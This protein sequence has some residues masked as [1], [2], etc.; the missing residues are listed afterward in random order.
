[1]T[2]W[3][4]V[5][6]ELKAIAS[7]KAIAITLFGGVLFYSVLYPLPYLHEVPT[8]QPIVVVDLDHSP[9]SRELI[10]HAQAS[11][12]LQVAGAVNA[13][14]E[15]KDWITHGRAHGLLVIPAHFS[16]D[17][18]LGKGATLAIGGDAS[19]F[20]VYSAIAEGL[21]SVGMDFSSQL[22]WRALTARGTNP[23]AADMQ[24]H[25]LDIN[26]VP[27]FNLS[28][29]YTPYVVPGL[30][31]L[32]L[33]QT[34]LVGT[35]ILGA[36]QWRKPG[37][38][39]QVSPLMLLGGRLLAF[40]AIYAC[41]SAYYVG[42]CYYWYKVNLL[43]SMVEILLLMVPFLLATAAGGV[44]LSTLFTRRELPTQ[45]ILLSS[46]PI[47]FVSGF[48]WPLALIPQPLVW[49]SQ[50]FPVTPA[51]MGMLEMNV[52]GAS[53]AQI[54]PYWWHLWLLAAIF[55]P[56]AWWGIRHHRQQL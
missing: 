51:I 41:F 45:V 44:A 27:A 46:M 16:R 5:W 24:L 38:W 30:F 25:P 32:I 1:M 36:G 33:Q 28:L 18:Q 17:L 35:C 34:M 13:I 43:A 55:L 2:W 3:K 48:V 10:R 49:L 26:S 8:R 39:Q 42:W 23:V 37:Y 50:V 6:L 52:M 29:G 9:M 47:L 22:K 7:D 15:A 14:A 20:L 53:W 4:L 56:L 11:P 19:Y 54:Q 21:V 31:L 40:G 12:K